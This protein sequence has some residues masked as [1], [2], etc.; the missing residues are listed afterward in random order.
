MAVDRED[1]WYTQSS[2]HQ[3]ATQPCGNTGTW[4]HLIESSPVLEY[5]HDHAFNSHGL[6]LLVGREY[7]FSCRA[8]AAAQEEY[9]L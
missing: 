6:Y 4:S 2:K 8:L 9:F 5:I 1:L 7:T 3:V